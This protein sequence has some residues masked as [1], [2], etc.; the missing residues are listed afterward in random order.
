MQEVGSK[1]LE[2]YVQKQLRLLDQLISGISEDIFWQTFPEILGI[3][4]KLNL[5]A[6]LIKC[7]DLSVDDIIRIVENDYVYYFKELC[8]YDLNMEINHSMI[9]NIL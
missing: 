4:A 3:D 1:N 8:G 5:I 2:K 6:E 9:F 7:Q